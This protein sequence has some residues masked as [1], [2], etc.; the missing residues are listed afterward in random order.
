MKCTTH[1]LSFLLYFTLPVKPR[2]GGGVIFVWP[3][4]EF[5]LFSS[6][7]FWPDC[8]KK[9][10]VVVATKGDTILHQEFSYWISPQNSPLIYSILANFDMLSLKTAIW[11]KQK[12][13]KG[14]E[15]TP[16]KFVKKLSAQNSPE[17]ILSLKKCHKNL[18]WQTMTR[19]YTV[20][21][22]NAWQLWTL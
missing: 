7:C 6:H 15:I 13:P 14:V 10:F 22:G 11:K 8:E 2:K 1:K 21:P 12:S 16:E 17:L 4:W 3:R 20:H 9:R 5:P 19:F 18:F